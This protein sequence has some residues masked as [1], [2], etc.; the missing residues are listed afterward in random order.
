[1]RAEAA[2]SQ[3]TAAVSAKALGAARLSHSD[4]GS[5]GGPKHGLVSEVPVYGIGVKGCSSR[6]LLPE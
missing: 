4:R 1:M 5:G 2:I 6:F 3:R